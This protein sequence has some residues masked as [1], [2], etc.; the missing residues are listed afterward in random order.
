MTVTPTTGKSESERHRRVSRHPDTDVSIRE[1]RRDLI[2]ELLLHRMSHRKIR[3]QLAR[4]VEE[5]GLGID[6]ATGTIA[7]DA[8]VIRS[9]WM[10]RMAEKFGEHVAEQMAYYD[11]LLRTL[12]PLA[13]TGD[14]L[15][16]TDLLAVLD[17]RARLV[18]MEAPDRVLVGVTT[19]GGPDVAARWAGAP[20]EEQIARTEK[21]LAILA[22]AGPLAVTPAGEPTATP[23]GADVIDI[24]GRRDD[25]DDE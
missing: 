2:A 5:G 1:A 16:V 11:A 20:R 25:G 22:E 7:S 8:A 13:L 4:P 10:A 17:R 18:G 24:A 21:I 15:A 6:V 3:E 19:P 23:V 14:H 9:R 12:T